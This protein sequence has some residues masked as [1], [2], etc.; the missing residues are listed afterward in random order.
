MNRTTIAALVVAATALL[1]ACGQD[2]PAAPTPTASTTTA[3]PVAAKVSRPSLVVNEDGSAVVTAFVQNVQAEKTSIAGI[4]VLSGEDVL[5]VL[6]TPMSMPLPPDTELRVGYAT[7][8]GGFVVPTGVTAGG[9]Y[10]LVLGFDNG[11][12]RVVASE[13]VERTDEHRAIY[14]R[15]KTFAGAVRSAR[16]GPEGCTEG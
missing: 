13:A 12:C 8:A 6:T 3:A 5:P 15:T 9:S 4:T 10:R 7:D 2:A 11:T 16:Q 14:P 1:A